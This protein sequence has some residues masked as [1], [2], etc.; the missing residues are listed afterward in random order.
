MDTEVYQHLSP[1]SSPKK[2]RNA[3]N[4]FPKMDAMSVLFKKERLEMIS[5]SIFSTSF[6]RRTNDSIAAF[7]LDY[8]LF[9]SACVFAVIFFACFFS[10]GRKGFM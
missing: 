5:R 10:F 8:R 9:A 6:W 4:F 2:S 7:L 1:A 3:N